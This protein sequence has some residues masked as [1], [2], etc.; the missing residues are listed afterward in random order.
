MAFNALSVDLEEYFQVSNFSKLIDHADWETLPS[1]VRESTLRLLDLFDSTQSRATFFVLGWIA[2]RHPRLLREIADRG[3]EI[4]CHGYGH[5]LVYRLGRDR[6]RRDLQ[7][8]RAAIEDAT[9]V[10]VQGYRAPSYSITAASLWAL[11]ILAEEGFNFDSS[12]FPIKHPRYGIP[13]FARWPVRLELGGGATIREYPLTTLACGRLN[14]PLA[15]GA[16]LRFLPPPLFRWGFARLQARGLP[17][18]L[19]VHPWEI[20]P[21]QPR[22]AVR[23]PVRINHYYNIRNTELRLAKLL[24]RFRF[25]TLSRVLDEYEAAGQLETYRFP[26]GE[27]RASV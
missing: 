9:G 11:P 17:T 3:H 10:A 6:F 22:Q 8:A 16:Y 5:E 1:R 27:A 15:G 21:D 13:G 24:R 25:S 20:D 7:R 14:L 4:A 12:I 18:V 26:P 19:Y 2:E 23:W